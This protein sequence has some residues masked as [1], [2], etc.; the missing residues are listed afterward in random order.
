MTNDWKEII[1]NT[2]NDHSSRVG[3]KF[4]GLKSS[5]E[6]VDDFLINKIQIL[7]HWWKMCVDTK[8]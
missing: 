2:E 4:H 7:Q 6:D 1:N 5:Y 3:Q 8:M